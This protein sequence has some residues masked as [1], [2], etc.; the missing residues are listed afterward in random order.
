MSRLPAEVRRQQLLD[1]ALETFGIGGYGATS[2]R[3]IAEAAG[4][5]KPV[6]YQHFTSKQALFREV[7]VECGRQLQE[8]VRVAATDAG[9]PREVVADG[10]RA[11]VGFFE[12][13]PAAFRILFSDSSRREP[14]FAREVHRVELQTADLIADLIAVENYDENDR[15]LLANGIVGLAEGAVRH[16]M[17]RDAMSADR[18]AELLTHL[19]WAGLRGDPLSV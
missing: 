7:L 9:S 2:M 4:V 8:A 1:V 6:L 5:T 16:W 13:K 17:E 3:E 11:W 18:V 14:D 15:R 10:F 12:Q 19:V